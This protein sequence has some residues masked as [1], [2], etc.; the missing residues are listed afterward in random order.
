MSGNNQA[1]LQL[2]VSDVQ[3]FPDAAHP[4]AISTYECALRDHLKTF[5]IHD[6]RHVS[7]VM[8]RWPRSLQDVMFAHSESYLVRVCPVAGP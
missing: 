6:I 7:R 1:I 8:G 3:E 5:V 2:S 4:V